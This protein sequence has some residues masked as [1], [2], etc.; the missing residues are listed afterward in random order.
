MQIKYNNFIKLIKN[1]KIK[2]VAYLVKK[3]NIEI[4]EG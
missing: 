3:L 2:D 1:V 4:L